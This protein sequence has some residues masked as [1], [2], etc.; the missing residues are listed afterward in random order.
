[1]SLSQRIEGCKR[2]IFERVAADTFGLGFLKLCIFV[3]VTVSTFGLGLFLKTLQ[4]FPSEVSIDTQNCVA[5]SP[6]PVTFLFLISPFLS[7]LCHCTYWSL[8]MLWIGWVGLHLCPD[9]PRALRGTAAILSSFGFLFFCIFCITLT[10]VRRKRRSSKTKK[11]EENKEEEEQVEKE[12]ERES[13][14]N[15]SN[16]VLV[17]FRSPSVPLVSP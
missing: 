16:T 10:F 11:R 9:V 14:N 6:I 12:K 5:F 13:D 1:M 3:F 17:V 2:C 8:R 15:T 4:F 7:S